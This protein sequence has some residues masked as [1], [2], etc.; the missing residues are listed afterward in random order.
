MPKLKSI[1]WLAGCFSL[2]VLGG[3]SSKSGL[4]SMGGNSAV[5]EFGEISQ[6]SIEYFTE[7][8]GNTILFEVN[9]STLQPDTI[10]NL[11]AQ[12]RWLEQNSSIPIT[13]EGHADEQGTREYNL[14]LGARRAT[15][16]RNFLVSQGIPESRLS[17]VTYG[18]ER[19]IEVC[20]MEKCWSQNRRSVTVVAGGLGS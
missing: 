20:S 6:S 9:K 16:V 12:A 19:P 5:S 11:Q 4:G 15:S 17:I 3:C 1:I 8:V 7:T 14:A 2:A 18:K 13:I 10:V